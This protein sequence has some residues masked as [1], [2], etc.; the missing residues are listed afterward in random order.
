LEHVIGSR[1]NAFQYGLFPRTKIAIK[2]ISDKWI[3]FLVYQKSQIKIGIKK[4][5]NRKQCKESTLYLLQKIRSIQNIN[6]KI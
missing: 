4:W 5:K 6:R 3:D 1:I 2:P